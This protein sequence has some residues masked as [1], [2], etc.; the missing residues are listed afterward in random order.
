MLTVDEIRE[1]Y[2]AFGIWADG[3]AITFYTD[4]LNE[5]AEPLQEFLST[6][7]TDLTVKR[8]TG[9]NLD[10][11]FKVTGFDKRKKL[12][13]VFDKFDKL[14]VDKVNEELDK[15]GW[16][17]A[18]IIIDS[19]GSQKKYTTVIDSV[20]KNDKN[21]PIFVVIYEAKYDQEVA[22]NEG[23]LYH[24]T[25]DSKWLRI[26]SIGL[27]PKSQEKISNHPGRIYLI[28]KVDKTNENYFQDVS[29]ILYKYCENKDLI[30]HMYILQIDISKVNNAKFYQD[31]N[32]F[33]GDAVWTNDNIPPYAIKKIDEIL[34]NKNYKKPEP[35]FTNLKLK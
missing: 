31:N 11:V 12:S 14:T 34:V 17:P 9:L 18:K 6:V 35:H 28:H 23:N 7:P 26:R 29:E 19:N 4:F 33:M 21:L 10:G 13:V 32:F 20:L 24:I 8:V 22:V 15:L 2:P 3:H 25:S 16:F 1:Q 27:T 5:N 30:E